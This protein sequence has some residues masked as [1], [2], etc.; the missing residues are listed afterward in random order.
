ML[1]FSWKFAETMNCCFFFQ[2]IFPWTNRFPNYIITRSENT[3]QHFM[4]AMQVILWKKNYGNY[5]LNWYLNYCFFAIQS[6]LGTNMNS[7]IRKLLVLTNRLSSGSLIY[8]VLTAKKTNMYTKSIQ[9][10]K[11]HSTLNFTSITFSCKK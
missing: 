5:W 9:N 11:K 4:L 8:F 6:A 1:T 7:R 3:F 10:E 2:E